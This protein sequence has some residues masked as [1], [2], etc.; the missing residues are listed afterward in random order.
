MSS[1]SVYL[2]PWVQSS[3]SLET[4]KTQ[5]WVRMQ[6]SPIMETV[7]PQLKGVSDVWE[8]VWLFWGPSIPKAPSNSYSQIRDETETWQEDHCLKLIQQS[9]KSLSQDCRANL[10]VKAV[11]LF[12]TGY[13]VHPIL[14]YV[15]CFPLFL[16][17]YILFSF[18]TFYCWSFYCSFHNLIK[19][20]PEQ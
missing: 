14:P 5:G 13:M 19:F 4:L 18:N 10:L 15:S 3:I 9:Q 1:G 7:P 2:Q 16:A 8:G 20:L 17:M 11:V 6:V 12:T